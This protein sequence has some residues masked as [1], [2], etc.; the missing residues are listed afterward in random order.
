MQRPSAAKPRTK[1]QYERCRDQAT[2]T[3]GHHARGHEVSHRC[4]TNDEGRER[5]EPNR[6]FRIEAM[7]ERIEPPL[8]VREDHHRHRRSGAD[9]EPPQPRVKRR[10]QADQDQCRDAEREQR[11]F[12][13]RRLDGRHADVMIQDIDLVNVSAQRGAVGVE[14][15]TARILRRPHGHTPE[16]QLCAHSHEP[17]REQPGCQAGTT[18]ARHLASPFQVLSSSNDRIT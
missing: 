4:F 15:E 7:A 14:M 10:Q 2:E 12:E 5:L 8:Q 6:C 1:K 9:R 13:C 3:P 16:R 11:G 18:C 17:R